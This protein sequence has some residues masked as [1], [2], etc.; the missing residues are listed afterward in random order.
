[1]NKKYENED[2]IYVWHS[3]DTL[4]RY[5]QEEP[6]DLPY[7]DDESYEAEP[8][9][10]PPR[11]PLSLSLTGANRG[12]ISNH[13]GSDYEGSENYEHDDNGDLMNY[14]GVYD[15]V[16]NDLSEHEGYQEGYDYWVSLKLT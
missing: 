8:S 7:N 6:S 15:S 5:Q 9:S 13:S 11:K 10:P 4:N 12:F 2:K 1:M 14:S 16:I 3:D